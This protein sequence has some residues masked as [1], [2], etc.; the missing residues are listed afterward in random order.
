MITSIGWFILSLIINIVYYEI[1]DFSIIIDFKFD[2]ANISII[3]TNVIS[4]IISIYLSFRLLKNYK[5]N[6]SIVNFAL[7]GYFLFSG[8]A[9][10]FVGID[11][12]MSFNSPQLI[13]FF[14]LIVAF[15]IPVSTFYLVVFLLEMFYTGILEGKSKYIF[16]LNTIF[17]IIILILG[18][19]I[20]LFNGSEEIE[21]L[22]LISIISIGI[23]YMICNI[24]YYFI[25]ALK[26]KQLKT[27]IENT[28][29]KKFLSLLTFSGIAIMMVYFGRIIISFFFTND[30]S[31]FTII[32]G[33][34]LDIIYLMGYIALYKGISSPIS[35][36]K[37]Q[38]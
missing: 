27:K 26:S 8:L 30:T 9:A 4:G 20:T 21:G 32:L 3:I 17:T 16:I 12:Y 37:Y 13:F 23:V 1:T 15:F 29:Y 35:N 5:K 38:K 25:L 10:L 31:I 14:S 6:S 7:V 19:T 18:L 36:K 34:I 2:F 33:F 11:T 28:K 22:A 24:I